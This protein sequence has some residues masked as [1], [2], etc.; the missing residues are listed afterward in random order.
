MVVGLGV[1]IGFFLMVPKLIRN[2][3]GAPLDRYLTSLS[4]NDAQAAYD[5]LRSGSKR[6]LTPEQCNE[7]LQGQLEQ[8]GKVKDIDPLRGKTGEGPHCSDWGTPV[9]NSR[10]R[11]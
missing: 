7:R 11:P 4:K 2:N 8:V 6:D 10:R 9:C 3:Y 5:M 1:L